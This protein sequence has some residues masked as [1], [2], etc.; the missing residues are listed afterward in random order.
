MTD[1]NMCL[2]LDDECQRILTKAKML[3]E[4]NPELLEGEKVAWISKTSVITV[5]IKHWW[6]EVGEAVYTKP[7]KYTIE[8][9]DE[10]EE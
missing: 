3:M 1:K 4:E 8:P 2:R 6:R 5:M 7:A 10:V 9:A